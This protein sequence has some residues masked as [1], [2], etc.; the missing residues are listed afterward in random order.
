MTRSRDPNDPY[1]PPHANV[2][3]FNPLRLTPFEAFSLAVLTA[4]LL[5]IAWLMMGAAVF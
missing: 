5:G 2:E 1:A 3:K 4:L